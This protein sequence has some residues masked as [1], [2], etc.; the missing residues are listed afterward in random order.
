MSAMS[1]DHASDTPAPATSRPVLLGVV[2]MIAA[3]VELVQGMSSVPTLFGDMSKIPGPGFGGFLIKAQIATQAP[4][5][6]AA[7]AVAAFWPRLAIIALAAIALMGW[8]G[9]MPSVVLH[10][11]E[12]GSAISSVETLVRIVAIPLMAVCAIALSAR[13]ERL[14]SAAALACFP[15]LFSMASVALFA[16]AVSIYGF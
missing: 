10:G 3:L 15:T 5:A 11:F 16:I 8:L 1:L 6:L 12:A 4:L 14:W 2:L 9:D 7:L 13:N